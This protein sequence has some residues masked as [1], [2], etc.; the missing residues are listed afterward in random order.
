MLKNRV[1]P[2]LLLKEDSLVKTVKF[3]KYKYIGDPLNTC[4]IF[5][6]LEVDEMIILDIRATLNNG[7]INYKL[8]QKLACECFMPLAYGGG[9]NNFEQAKELFRIGFEKIV[10]NSSTYKTTELIREISETFGVQSIIC[11][12]DVKKNFFGKY[13]LFSASGTKRERVDLITWIK[14][15]EAAGA[16]EI[17][18]TDIKR[19]GTWKGFDIELIQQII[20][21]T[22]I[23]LIIHGG[24]GCAKDIEDAVNIGGASAVALGSMVV[25]QK[26][27][28]GVLINY[29]NKYNFRAK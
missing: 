28:M 1:I 21:N 9:I 27:E 11:S 19:E 12:V 14:E 3:G 8:L 23:P 7:E 26:Q 17:I 24:A 16:G 5:N 6:E 10:I 2:C 20:H 29:T 25:Y 22:N 13:E 18:L 4:R 15:L